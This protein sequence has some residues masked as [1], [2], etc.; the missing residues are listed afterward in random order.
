MKVYSSRSSRPVWL[1]VAACALLLTASL[2]YG[3]GLPQ[4]NPERGQTLA[5]QRCVGCHGPNGQSQTPTF[6]SLAAQ[7][8]SYLSTQ[9]ILLR[10]GIRQS[11]VMNAIAKDLSDQDIADLTAYY[12]SQ[13]PRAPWPASDPELQA[14]GKALFE[15]GDR[16]RGLIACAICHG[17][18][19]QGVNANGIP[20]IAQQ[21]PDYFINVMKVFAN[22]DLPPGES[23]FVDAMILTAKLLTEDELKALAEYVKSMP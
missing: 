21:S 14:K 6:P 15:K 18:A 2:T 23:P 10:A 20:R 5:N 1:L 22:L 4:S 11:P 17:P 9:L 19:G 13:P 12:A 16:T 3:Q 8:P 7:V